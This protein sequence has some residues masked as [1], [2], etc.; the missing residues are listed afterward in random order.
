MAGDGFGL[1][2][3]DTWQRLNVARF[4]NGWATATGAS[5]LTQSMVEAVAHIPADEPERIAPIVR[6]LGA[7][8]IAR[9][10]HD[11]QVHMSMLLMVYA[12]AGQFRVSGYTMSGASGGSNAMATFPPVDGLD[13][14][15]LATEWFDALQTFLSFGPDAWAVI[16]YLA[17]L[18]AEISARTNYGKGSLAGELEIGLTI[19]ERQFYMSPTP[20]DTILTSE[21]L[22]TLFVEQEIAA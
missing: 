22:D 18:D 14:E 13:I 15:L 9:H 21:D 20:T 12:R 1:V 10:P 6:E 4:A 7:A 3:T 11:R 2:A 19:G 17:Q 5:W 8:A 16:R